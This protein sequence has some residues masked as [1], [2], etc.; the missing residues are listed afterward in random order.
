MT[1]LGRYLNLLT[2]AALPRTS[3]A[4]RTREPRALLEAVAAAG[5]DGVQGFEVEIGG[6]PAADP[7]LCNELGLGCV[8]QGRRVETVG[9]V[10]ADAARWAGEGFESATLHVGFGHESD[11]EV[12][13]LL[14]DVVTASDRH[15]IPL[16]VE[17]HRGTVTQDTWRTVRMVG[18]RPELRFN[19]DF[20]HWY[21]GLEMTYG[22]FDAR[23]AFLAPVFERTRFL[24]GRIGE[25]GAI[26]IDV[27]EGDA[28]AHP[29]VAHFEQ[30]WTAAFRGFLSHAHPDE[31]IVFAPELLP[32]A[33]GYART[34]PGADGRRV[35]EGDRWQQALVLT[36]IAGRCY[37][38]A[39]AE[40]GAATEAAA[41]DAEVAATGVPA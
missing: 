21:T 35:E 22:D 8:A 7:A 2:L 11:D 37:A 39:A 32:A 38:E 9:T 10:G 36:R 23:L 6:V 40:T 3:A 5:Y 20:S 16:Y 15:G 27:G 1:R 12:R 14:D 18:E 4:P 26:Q 41:T 33:I 30:F 13:A 19:G 31:R 34:A 24:H 29:S 25:S 17:T 28:A